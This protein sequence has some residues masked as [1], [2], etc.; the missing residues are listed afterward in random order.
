MAG[1]S[2]KFPCSN[3]PPIFAVI[4]TYEEFISER[5]LMEPIRLFYKPNREWHEGVHTAL[6]ALAKT[7]EYLPHSLK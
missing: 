3:I 2:L 7:L 6:N 1:R 4:N 5:E